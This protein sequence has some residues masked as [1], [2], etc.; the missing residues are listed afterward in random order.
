MIKTL[1]ITSV[2]AAILAGVFFV[3]PVIYGVRKDESVDKLLNLPSVKKKFE[4]DVADSKTK[5]GQSPDSPLVKQA[6]AFALYLNP[7]KPS[8]RKPP[9]KG[10]KIPSISSKVNVTP[11]FT[12]LATIV[13]PDN[14][15]LS[16]AL[17]NEPGS[18]RHWVR[19]S[20]IVGHLFVEQIKEGIVV[21]KS[22]DEITNLE[23]AEKA[24]TVSTG[25]PSTASPLI[26][27]RMPTKPQAT[28]FSRAASNVTRTRS[29]P[30]RAPINSRNEEKIDELV[31]KLKDLQ[32][33]SASDKTD[34]KIDPKERNARIQE[35]ISKY[36]SIRVSAE[37]SE[38]LDSM[39]EEMKDIQEDPNL[40]SPPES[41]EDEADVNEVD[42]G[43][44]VEED[45]QPKSAKTAGK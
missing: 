44:E 30:K 15:M 5:T 18:G 24:G 11:K 43:V 17:I 3:F 35:L 32:K 4:K 34:S 7:L 10:G 21:L 31:D 29:I 26:S 39:G 41:G 14:P 36:K 12:V 1:R 16:Q 22:G 8:I 13:Y 20:T 27:N 23:I 33:S 45:N 25:K 28:A 38:K 40:L 6:E 2:V 9:I 42:E 19:Q 37:E